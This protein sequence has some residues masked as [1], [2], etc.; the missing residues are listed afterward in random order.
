MSLIQVDGRAV[1]YLLVGSG[2]EVVV[3][4]SPNFWPLDAWK[5]SGIPELRDAYRVLAFNHR[6]YGQS[7]PT[8]TEY[9]VY[10]LADDTLALMSA[11]GIERAHLV[12]FAYGAQ[13]AV[14][15]ALRQPERVVTLV[16]GAAGAGAASDPAAQVRHV[17]DALRREG[18]RD[19]IR[20]HALN[21]DF[22]FHPEVYRAHPERA[23]ALADAMWEHAAT[24]AEFLKHVA[25]RNGFR[26]IDDVERIAQPALVIVGEE[27]RAA[28]GDT[29][30]VE[31][32]PVLAERLPRAE[33]AI[34]PR[35]RHMLFWERPEECW[36]L[37]KRFLAAHP[38]PS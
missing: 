8:P 31:F 5:L 25:A 13:V 32:A 19:Y 18:Y 28:R 26:T 2:A 20:N 35:T 16:L 7:A 36:P 33:L 9:T 27:D 1:E 12:G 4:C 6:G 30:P 11:L 38:A 21:E 14:K 34:V 17:E 10:S 37:V 22:A 23:V 24:E 15:A 3:L 29:T